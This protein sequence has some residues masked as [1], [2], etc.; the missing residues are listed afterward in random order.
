MKFTLEDF[1]MITNPLFWV[2]MII[3][4]IY[5][6]FKWM[7]TE[8]GIRDWFTII[9]T[10]NPKVNSKSEAKTLIDIFENMNHKYWLK[11][12]AWEYLEKRIKRQFKL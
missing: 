7:L 6:F 5:E 1:F 12:R 8:F 4:L 11:R 2:W 3:S 10:N 9:F